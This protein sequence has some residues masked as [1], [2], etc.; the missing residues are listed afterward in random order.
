ML[1]GDV[2]QEFLQFVQSMPKV[3][4]VLSGD[5][6]LQPLVDVLSGII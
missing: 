6:E 2:V 1:A 4:N 5:K 3:L